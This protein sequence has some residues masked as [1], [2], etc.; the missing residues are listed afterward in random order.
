MKKVLII[1]YFYPPSNFVGGERIE[2][3]AKELHK[4]NLYPVV[5]TRKWNDGQTDLTDRIENNK[6]EIEKHE[7]YE[8]HRLPHKET[9]RDKLAQ[10]KKFRF[11]QKALTLKELVFSNFSINALSFSN[12]YSYSRKLIQD[13]DSFKVIIASGRPFQSF[14]IGYKLKKVFPKLLWIPDYR[15]EWTTHKNVSDYSVGFKIINTLERK[16]EKT[17]TSNAD[18]FIGTSNYWNESINKLINKPSIQVMNGYKE[19][20]REKFNQFNEDQSL[21]ICYAGTLYPNQNIELLIQTIEK[22]ILQHKRD[23]KL[24]FVG[25]NMIPSELSRVQNLSS[26]IIESVTILPRVPRENLDNIIAT[27]DIL[28]LT[29]F[30]GINGWMPVKLFDYYATGKPI[31]LSP[32]DGGVMEAFVNETN[33]GFTA[34]SEKELVELIDNIHKD[35]NFIKNDRSNSLNK[36]FSRSYQTEILA[37]EIKNRI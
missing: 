7:G 25:I 13:D 29:G 26:K 30:T 18:F 4:Y 11:I 32:G 1:S 24:I 27:A 14:F 15:D 20:R 37:R 23:I 2:T 12:F 8:V 22:Q 3:W 19:D 9:L 16:S 28:F 10:K 31:L 33:C 34:N 5:I 36:K 6:L 17:W 21:T 35:K